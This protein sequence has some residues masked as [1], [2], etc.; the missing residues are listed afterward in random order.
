MR[1]CVLAAKPPRSP[2]VKP[3]GKKIQF[4]SA[5]SFSR[6]C[7]PSNKQLKNPWNEAVIRDKTG[8]L[9]RLALFLKIARGEARPVGWHQESKRGNFTQQFV[10][11]KVLPN[12]LANAL[13]LF[14]CICSHPCP[15][16]SVRLLSSQSKDDHTGQAGLEFL[17]TA[18]VTRYPKQCCLTMIYCCQTIITIQLSHLPTRTVCGLRR[19]L[20]KGTRDEAVRTSSWDARCSIFQKT[21]RIQSQLRHILLVLHKQIRHF[22]V[23]RRGFVPRGGRAIIG[24]GVSLLQKLTEFSRYLSISLLYSIY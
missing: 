2:A 13:R 4:D 5:K 3:C 20:W 18:Q 17:K 12:F 14:Y 9:S 19:T 22:K 7:N 6:S 11:L 1:K 8:Q 16:A 21:L 23:P 24:G 10:P 15:F